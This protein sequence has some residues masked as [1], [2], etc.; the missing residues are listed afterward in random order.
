MNESSPSVRCM[1]SSSVRN[2]GQKGWNWNRRCAWDIH[3][4]KSTDTKA[5]LRVAAAAAA[6]AGGIMKLMKT[7]MV[8]DV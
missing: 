6:V 4:G 5:V 2:C 1:L 3:I 8:P 7:W